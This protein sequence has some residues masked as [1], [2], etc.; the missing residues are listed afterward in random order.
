MITFYVRL[1]PFS[2]NQV[3]DFLFS[4]IGCCV[5]NE[6]AETALQLL[7]TVAVLQLFV[8]KFLYAAVSSIP[9]I[10]SLPFWPKAASVV[11]GRVEKQLSL[12]ASFLYDNV[13]F[14]FVLKYRSV[15]W[16]CRIGKKPFKT[17]KRFWI[18]KLHLRSSLKKSR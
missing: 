16:V 13:V 11:G 18:R 3:S 17:S 4:L 15:G 14:P 12:H 1:K 10:W 2:C 6:Q 7:G 9:L 5:L 8:K